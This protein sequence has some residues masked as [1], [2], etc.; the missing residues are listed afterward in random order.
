LTST[1]VASTLS[2]ANEPVCVPEIF[3]A[4]DASAT[5]T[6]RM[7]PLALLEV[8]PVAPFHAPP[9]RPDLISPVMPSYVPPV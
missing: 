7:L 9:L 6:D 8:M 5:P 1:V 4:A 2:P 3:S